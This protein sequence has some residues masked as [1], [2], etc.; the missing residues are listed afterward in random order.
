[1]RPPR[2]RT[3]ETGLP[4]A[5]PLQGHGLRG[6]LRRADG[7]KTEE[8]RPAGCNL[9]CSDFRAT[10]LYPGDLAL[11]SLPEGNGPRQD[12]LLHGSRE[13]R[14]LAQSLDHELRQR[15]PQGGCAFEGSISVARS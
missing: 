15:E 1:H 7:A 11:R 3:L 9:E 5:L 8:I 12:R 2:G 4:A 6:I 10:A 14:G 13:L